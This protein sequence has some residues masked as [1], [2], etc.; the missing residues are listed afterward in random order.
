MTRDYFDA[1]VGS[2]THIIGSR[3]GGSNGYC[4]SVCCDNVQ[5]ISGFGPFYSITVCRGDV[6]REGGAFAETNHSVA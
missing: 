1:K 6:D 5:E 4:W 3:I 2:N